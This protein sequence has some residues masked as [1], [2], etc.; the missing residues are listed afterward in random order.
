[1]SSATLNPTILYDNYN[2]TLLYCTVLYCTV[3]YCAV[4]YCTVLCCVLQMSVMSQSPSHQ[5]PNA[6]FA[7]PLFFIYSPHYVKIIIYHVHKNW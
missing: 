3:L 4:L 7:L 2:Y 1:M 6:G 5:V